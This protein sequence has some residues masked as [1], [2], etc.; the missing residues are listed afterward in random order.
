MKAVTKLLQLDEAAIDEVTDAIAEFC[1]QVGTE[2]KDMLRYRLSA[3]ECLLYWLDHGLRGNQVSFQAGRF[4]RTP[5]IMLEVEGPRLNPYAD[6]DEDYGGEF[7]E[8]VLTS[9]GLNPEYS[10]AKGRNRIRFR[11]KKKS[12]GQ[13]ATLCIALGVAALVGVLGTIAIPENIL[14]T[15]LNF[16]IDPL[17]GLFFK[18]LGCI[19]GPMIFLSVAWGV[20]GIGDTATFGKIGRR[21]L[22]KYVL[23]TFAAAA[24]C[25]VFFPLLGPDLS[26]SPS[27]AGQL[28]AIAEMLFSIFPANIVEPFLTGNT[29]QIIFMAIIVGIALLYLGRQTTLIAKAIDEVNVLVQFLMQFITKLVPFVIFLVVLSMIWSGKLSVLATTW[30][31]FVALLSAILLIS[32]VFVAVASIRMKVS[33]LTLIRKS[34]PTFLIALTTASSAAAFGTSVESCE[35]KFGVDKSVVKFGIPL[36][37]VIQKPMSAAFFLL[38]VFFF[39]NQY[40]IDCSIGWICAAVFVSAVVAIAAP[41]VPGGSAVAFSALFIPMGIPAEALAIALA[42]DIVAD[43]FITAFQMG[44]LQLSLVNISAKM[45]MVD[46]NILR[47]EA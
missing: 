33:P 28:D 42:L 19:A 13:I 8:S 38:I 36:G 24:A 35:E 43:F 10:H 15:L 41:P 7:A 37:M 40:G 18:I 25:S 16:V 1:Q 39:A 12:L 44:A 14:D 46:V 23:V 34:V 31:L 27:G 4:M 30:K 21:M 17:Y 9:L 6:D 32:A 11:I 20:Y 26:Y 29:L 47:K 2:H 45:G 5:N 3:E 22:L